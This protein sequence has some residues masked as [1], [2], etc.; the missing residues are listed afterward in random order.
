MP[1]M[2]TA[3]IRQSLRIL[4]AVII[5]T[6]LAAGSRTATASAMPVKDAWM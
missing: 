5:M 1:I 6:I 4:V 2:D 3:G